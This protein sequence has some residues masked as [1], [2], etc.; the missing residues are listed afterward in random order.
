MGRRERDQKEG[1]EK[2]RSGGKRNEVQQQTEI[3]NN[4]MDEVRTLDSEVD[5]IKQKM[6]LIIREINVLKHVVLAEKTDLKNL[7]EEETKDQSRFESILDIVKNMRGGGNADGKPPE[8][9]Q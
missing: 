9:P 1:G 3:V 4:L 2:A 8:D 6:N 5:L 7:Q